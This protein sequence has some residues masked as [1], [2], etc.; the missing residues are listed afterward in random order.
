[1]VLQQDTLKILHTSQE[2]NISNDLPNKHTL[3]KAFIVLCLNQ[4]KNSPKI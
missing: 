3:F 1:M 2:Q 4:R